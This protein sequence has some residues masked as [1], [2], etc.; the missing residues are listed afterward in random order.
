MSFD[1]RE[2]ARK[3][4]YRVRNLHDGRPLLPLRVPVN[5]RGRAAGYKARKDRMDAI[6]CARG[7]VSCDAD[8][9]LAWYLLAKSAKGVNRWLPKLTRLGA[10]VQQAGDHEVAG[11]APID[12]IESVLSVLK[13]Y[14]R[15]RR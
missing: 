7:Y 4:R 2:Y 13:P 6:I 11:V 1:I 3:H 9:K 14:R 15:A 12:E 8:D 10:V 5:G